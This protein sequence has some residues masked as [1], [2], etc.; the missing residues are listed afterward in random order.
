MVKKVTKSKTPQDNT[1]KI[2]EAKNS[3]IP[4]IVFGEY[5]N[6]HDQLNHPLTNRLIAGEISALKDWSELDDSLLLASFMVG[7]GY[8]PDTF[9]AWCL[10]FPELKNMV[11]YVKI[12]IGCRREIGAMLRKYDAGMVRHTLG[13][14][15]K[16]W[17]DESEL[18][19]K[20]KDDQGIPNITVL[21]DSFPSRVDRTDEENLK[22]EAQTFKKTPEQLG[23]KA[24]RTTKKTDGCHNEKLTKDRDP[25]RTPKKKP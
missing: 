6:M 2:L 23:A 12:K 25:W 8:H 15:S 3:G 18:L 19:A 20:Q 24:V 22:F 5:Y 1:E 9:D 14:Y 4:L 13:H 16:I 10:K 11:S 7:R 21:M 17:R